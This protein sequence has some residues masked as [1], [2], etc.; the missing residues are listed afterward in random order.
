MATISIITLDFLR[1]RKKRAKQGC[2]NARTKNY[3]ILHSRLWELQRLDKKL[4][5]NIYKEK[6]DLFK[7]EDQQECHLKKKKK[8]HPEKTLNVLR[9]P[10]HRINHKL[11]QSLELLRKRL[12]FVNRDLLVSSSS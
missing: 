3:S 10:V 2:L 12:S 7:L 8:L 6:N 1:R 9:I 5:R 11:K 4:H